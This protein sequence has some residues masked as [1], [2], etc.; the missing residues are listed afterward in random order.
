MRGVEPLRI[1]RSSVNASHRESV[2][3]SGSP[4][5]PTV[6]VETRSLTEMSDLQNHHFR[7]GVIDRF[8]K[9]LIENDDLRAEKARVHCV[10][11]T[12]LC[13]S[14]HLYFVSRTHLLCH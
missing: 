11:D 14:R 4:S 1:L 3:L 5:L 7:M 8:R 9:F 6:S 2:S 10:P 13:G 12:F